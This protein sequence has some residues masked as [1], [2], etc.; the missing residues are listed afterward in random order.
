MSES[1]SE[2]HSV[3]RSSSHGPHT[4]QTCKGHHTRYKDSL[5][6]RAKSQV[7]FP[8]AH[9]HHASDTRSHETT[10]MP[11]EGKLVPQASLF[12]R[13]LRTPLASTSSLEA[14]S[15]G[16]AARLTLETAATELASVV[17]V[18][19]LGV[20]IRPS[21]HVSQHSDLRSVMA[22][23]P[24]HDLPVVLHSL[25][26]HPNLH[27]RYTVCD[28]HGLCCCP[29]LH[30]R[31]LGHTHGVDGSCRGQDRLNDRSELRWDA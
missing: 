25:I 1:L 29:G 14:L 9:Q 5:A 2:P 6:I 12:D 15:V 31:R 10:I 18:S 4:F 28:R 22:N 7:R 17:I 8:T 11:I 19:S 16:L 26:I 24:N 27:W 23:R 13:D 3:S 30:A 21:L 20:A